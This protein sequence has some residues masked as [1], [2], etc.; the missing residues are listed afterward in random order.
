[1][2][3]T[4]HIF[5]PPTTI[6]NNQVMKSN[7]KPTLK[8]RIMNSKGYLPKSVG[9]LLVSIAIFVSLNLQ[10]QYHTGTRYIQL[11]TTVTF[12]HNLIN[13]NSQYGILEMGIAL[14]WLVPAIFI[15]MVRVNTVLSP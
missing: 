15:L 9:G 1:L 14:P 11:G 2:E 7:V 8:A 3:F 4:E 6:N 13:T 12:S 5:A 10:G